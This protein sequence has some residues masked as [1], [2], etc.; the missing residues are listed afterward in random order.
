MSLLRF[1][2]LGG[3]V[4]RHATRLGRVAQR[5]ASTSSTRPAVTTFS[6]D[7]EMLRE[8][9]AAFA[10][11]QVQP[12]VATM[13]EE[14]HMPKELIDDLFANGLL[15]VEMPEE[16]GGTNASFTSA[17]LTIEELAKVD[18]SVS[19]LVDIHNTLINNMFKF[20]ASDEL[21]EEWCPRLCTDTLGSFC[22]SE[23]GSGSDAFAL[24]T[25]AEKS[26]DGSYYTINGSKMWISNAEHA[27]VFLVMANVDPS[28]GYKGITCFVVD[29]KTAGI[30]VGQ[31]ENKLG[32]RASSTCPVHFDNVKVPSNSILGE[33]GSGY[34]YVIAFWASIRPSPRIFTRVCAQQVRN[35]DLKRRSHWNWSANGRIGARSFQ[36]YDAV[37]VAAEAIWKL[38]RGLSRHGTPVSPVV[39]HAVIQSY[40]PK[41]LNFRRPC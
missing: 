23:S 14:S 21:K 3:L 41:R 35:P 5:A 32:I 9:V 37:S 18:A 36:L 22:L 4:A 7:E 38:H 26:S 34:K 13:D 39:S 33:I 20:W 2:N 27:G 30:E 24:K 25:T 29:A 15:G 8:A 40:I 11:Q 16:W 19:V 12:L 17:I 10:S 6:E 28:A 1:G 31:K